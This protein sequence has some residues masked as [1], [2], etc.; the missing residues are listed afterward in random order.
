M[1]EVDMK[2]IA[3]IVVM[4]FLIGSLSQSQRVVDLQV[5]TFKSLDQINVADLD[6]SKL[7][8][9]PLLF[10]VGITNLTDSPIEL[11]LHFIVTASI[12]GEPEDIFADAWTQPFMVDK[13]LRFTNQDLA[14]GTTG[15]KTDKNRTKVYEDKITK[16]KDV[17]LER[18]TGKLPAGI[19]NFMI[20]L[21][22]AGDESMAIAQWSQV[23]EITNPT[24]ID[25]VLPMDDAEVPTLFPVFQWNAEGIEEFTIE[26]YE[27]LPHQVT[28]EEVVSGSQNLRWRGEGI[29]NRQVQYPP[30][31]TPLEDG[32]IYYWLVKA[33][34]MGSRGLQE[35]RSEI[36]KFRVKMQTTTT[37][38]GEEETTTTTTTTTPA[39][40]LTQEER[41]V[42]SE[43]GR[44]FQQTG[45]SE[46]VLEILRQAHEELTIL[47]D[48]KPVR[49]DEILNMLNELRKTGK[50]EIEVEIIQ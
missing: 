21:Y 30:T 38:G 1:T 45:V 5:T 7:E 43:I 15:I 2:R 14:A 31:A 23:Y 4:L 41:Q 48:G 20:E 11:V 26:V 33:E 9:L 6:L 32:K 35:I 40:N 24:K 28:P 42:I 18:G 34:V 19:Y 29:R 12:G 13:E 8:N 3:L 46:Q 39:D 10:I 25:L 17:A 16:I 37:A 47:V 50:Y 22:R 36:W 44:I 49:V 27:K